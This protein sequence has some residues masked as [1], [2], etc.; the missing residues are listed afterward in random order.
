MR[1]GGLL[2]FL[3]SIELFWYQ[4]SLCVLHSLIDYR[5]PGLE[6]EQGLHNVVNHDDRAALVSALTALCIARRD[7]V[8]AGDDYGR[9]VLAPYGFIQ[10]EQRAIL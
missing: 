5:L 7:F 4:A 1:R 10:P 8:A 3:L 2:N 6:L 9:S